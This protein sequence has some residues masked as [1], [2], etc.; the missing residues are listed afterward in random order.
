MGNYFDGTR[1]GRRRDAAIAG[2]F[3]L[4]ALLLLLVPASY[5]TPLRSAIRG[6]ALRPFLA[7]QAELVARR[8]RSVDV[9]QLRAERDSLAAVVAAQASLAEEN[10]RLRALLGLRSRAE[11][12]FRPAELVRAGVPGAESTFFID[13]GARDGVVVGS[14]VLAAGGLLG[15]IQ[16]VEEHTAQGIDWTHPHFRA[17]AMTADG[18]AYGIVEPRR[19]RFREEDLLTLTGAPFHTDIRPGTR[20]VTTGRGGIYPRGIPLGTVVGID[21]AD[22]GWRKNYLLRPA[23]RP[24][25]VTHVIVAI[26][27]E[28]ETGDLSPLWQAD[29][30]AD[31]QEAGAAEE[32]GAGTR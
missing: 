11:P 30:P 25:G 20:V 8:A 19:G 4:L 23:V 2:G 21:E 31:T 9:S 17:S 12:D 5:Q 29:A 16:A 22:T 15:V 27:R 10:R 6:T 1:R 18:D 24:E 14:P 26:R 3:L 13:I 7:V 28:G 32:G